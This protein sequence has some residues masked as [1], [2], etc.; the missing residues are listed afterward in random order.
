MQVP[1][2]F[3]LKRLGLIVTLSVLV[4][5][6]LQASLFPQI[7]ALATPGVNPEVITTDPGNGST[8]VEPD[9]NIAVVFNEPMDPNS[10]NDR[11]V[12]LNGSVS[13]G[14]LGRSLSI[15][16]TLLTIDP[17]NNFA[18]GET[19]TVLIVGGTGPNAVRDIEGE[20]MLNNYQFS[21]RILNDQ[22]PPNPPTNLQA[23]GHDGYVDLTWNLSSS[24][25]VVGQTIYRSLSSGGPY[26][27]LEGV[28]RDVT[29]YR[30]SAVTNG[31][32]YYYVITARDKAGNESAYSNE[33]TA[34][35]SVSD[36]NP[37]YCRNLNPV[38]GAQNVPTDTNIYLEIWDDQSGV[39]RRS[40]NLTVEGQDIIVN[41]AIQP[42]FNV[43]LNSIGP[44]PNGFAIDYDPSV[45]FNEYQNINVDITAF[46]RSPLRNQMSY[47]YAFRIADSTP[48][49]TDNYNPAP[50]QAGVPVNSNVVF[51]IHDT[52][53]GVNRNSIRV[54]V[55]GTVYRAGIPGFSTVN[56][57]DGYRVTINPA[58]N[59]P[60]STQIDVA[61]DARDDAGNVMPTFNYFFTTASAD[62][63]EPPY[64]TNLNPA[65][66]QTGVPVNT[67]IYF[68]ILDSGTG[69]DLNTVDLIVEGTTIISNGVVQPG[70]NVTINAIAQGFS[71]DYD[72]SANFNEYQTV[73]VTVR[74]SDLAST[75]NFMQ[76]DYWFRTGD[77]T[78]PYVNGRVPADG[79][80]N[81]PVDTNVVFHVL[82]DG[83]GVNILTVVAIVDGTVYRFGIPGFSFA[84]TPADYTITIDP[85]S[86]FPYNT[87]IPVAIDAMDVEGNVMATDNY[88][89][90]TEPTADT[91]PP[92]VQNLNPAPG[93]TNVPVNTNIYLE[94]VDDDSGV[95][96]NTID[97]TVEGS[98]IVD[99]GVVQPGYT[100]A[101]N[102]IANGY[103][104]D[105]DPS[106]NFNDYQQVDV[107]IS[108]SDLAPVPNSFSYNYFFRTNDTNP[109]YTN[110]YNPTP[111]DINVPVN[112][113]V[114][115]HVLDDGSGVNLMTVAANVN[116]VLYANGIPGFSFVGT[117]ADY[118]IIINPA[119]NFPYNTVIPVTL[120]ATDLDGN[121]MTPFSYSFTTETGADLL[122]PYVQNEN[123]QP[124]EVNVPRNTNIYFE[125]VD[126]QSGVNLGSVDVTVEGNLIV[127]DGVAQLGY[128][129][130]ITPIANGYS[131]DYDPSTDFAY[132]Q[133]VD[134]SIDAADNATPPNVM[135]TYNY[136]FTI[137]NVNDTTA[138]VVQNENPAPG[139]IN[140]PVNTN[141]YLEIVDAGTGV[142]LNTVNITVE[143]ATI[144]VNGVVQPGYTVAV[145]PI[146][147]G[148][149]F[150]YDPTVDFPANATINVS[151]DAAD[152]MTPPNVMPTYNYSF[153][154]LDTIP[155]QLALVNP[156]DPD[157][158]AT[159]VPV[160][161][162]ITFR[163][164]EA[165]N[166]GTLGAD[167]V[168][169]TGS[170]SGT[171][172]GTFT[173]TATSVTFNP[174]NNFVAG[175]VIT[176][177]VNTNAQDL[178]GNGLDGDRDGVA[179]GS[180]VD[181]YTI[182]FTVAAAGDTTPPNAPVV[183]SPADGEVITDNTPMIFGTAEAGS[184]VSIYVDD[185][186]VV[187]TRADSNGNFIYTMT[188]E[189]DRGEHTVYAYATD[190]AG[191]RSARSNVNTFI[192]DTGSI[193]GA[194]TGATGGNWLWISLI[195]AF[196]AALGF[197]TIRAFAKVR[198]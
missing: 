148:Y 154:T 36:T 70:Y 165:M 68:E 189:L 134:V 172:G 5:F 157:N 110:G 50:G 26:T 3:K 31:T 152:L 139:A 179:E 117:P 66:T 150:D 132:G 28:G 99:D 171:I 120:Y 173:T 95:D 176:A 75:P 74:A 142:D 137:I 87:V 38:P 32:T 143:G 177:T 160:T 167:T 170:V 34:T 19:V 77:L 155:P 11:N 33:A 69:V 187:T 109:P 168:V 153:D 39:A 158:G 126:D 89:F 96:V 30:D 180:P 25:D 92:Y 127:D 57:P 121:V 86:N 16:G 17:D 156:S 191:N 56:L 81:V 100:V 123:P 48:P 9:T 27:A 49:Y 129:V 94:V 80:I 1:R 111:G 82:D 169:T 194:I 63:T 125:V 67:N 64:V 181:D 133:V 4:L 114:V 146:A 162:N 98:L 6:V 184:D 8:D 72:P 62:D 198:Q 88:S 54:D 91:E 13:G 113:D 20:P 166:Q 78:P 131:F 164:N 10:F 145:N 24:P 84:G 196:L 147:N 21:F 83:S 45:N 138:P 105:Y 104:L 76:Y 128:A 183:I 193:L 195:L 35:P 108:A 106:V 2:I 130:T 122:P 124:G 18:L 115:F 118:T 79:D 186:E 112:T 159:N 119:T 149:N 23:T 163:F 37:P 71:F 175:E 151:V 59:F 58:S 14:P 101:L 61:I 12:I 141:V 190:A 43:T 97:F 107:T 161:S 60:Y 65:P 29:T 116:G 185:V 53:S 44:L 85:A 178:A 135:A 42:G 47:S 102:P 55:E 41:G 15:N 188:Q 40:I 103:S 73:N 140:V 51:E 7:L 182:S 192:V 144:V 174:T 52:G 197:V 46:D 93:Q 90:T 22:T 136:S